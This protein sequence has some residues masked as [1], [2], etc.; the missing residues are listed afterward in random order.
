MSFMVDAGET[1][2]VIRLAGNVDIN[3]AAEL[4]RMLIETISSEKELRVD[5][6][7]ATDLD[8]TAIQL[9]WAAAREADKLGVSFSVAGQVPENIRCAVRDAGFE[10]LLASVVP[11]SCASDSPC[12]ANRECDDRR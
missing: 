5:L 9:L 3:C 4:K 8:I 1:R 2:D 7:N 10:N 6:A 12:S 11:E